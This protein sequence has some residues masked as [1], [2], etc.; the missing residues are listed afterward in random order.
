MI[1][2]NFD[3]VSKLSNIFF[4]MAIFIGILIA[5]SLI[6]FYNN[7]DI[8][9]A[10]TVD[11]KDNK[12]TND[13]KDKFHL[14]VNINLN[15]IKQVNPQLF[16]IVAFVNGDVQTKIIDLKKN[17]TIS[18]NSMITTPFDFN[19]KNDVSQI[20]SG[21]EYFV[22]GYVLKSES[23]VAQQSN[24]NF[25]NKTMLYDCNEGRLA[26]P[27]KGTP[28]IF[29]ALN[30]YDTSVSMYQSAL[31][32]G[33][34]DSKEIK[35]ILTNPT[36]VIEHLDNAK[37]V[38]MIKGDYQIKKININDEIKKSKD[39][40]V[41]KVPFTFNTNTEIGPIQIGDFFFGCITADGYSSSENSECENRN[42]K[43][44]DKSNDLPVAH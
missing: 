2:Q 31:N 18:K 12:N 30:K 27:D 15:N 3:Y 36:N 14:T 41:L 39:K 23:N 8:V 34:Q 5:F 38:A 17:A 13:N 33:V 40:N 42:I 24:P 7:I 6:M 25:N 1:L 10:T 21:D 16:K 4:L 20:D 11:E 43:H 28:N 37:F 29:S 19:K 32:A 22:C 9:F 35:I 44:F 26:S